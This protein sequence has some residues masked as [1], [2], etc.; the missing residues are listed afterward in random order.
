M[1]TE[2]KTIAD[3]KIFAEQL[4]SEGVSFHPD[5]DFEDYIDLQSKSPF[6]S[7]EQAAVRNR[8]IEQSFEICERKGAD[9]YEIMSTN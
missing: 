1:I 8:L 3:V 2:I 4:V 5:D 7:P 9:I 6:Y